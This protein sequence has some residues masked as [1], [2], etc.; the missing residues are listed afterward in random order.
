MKKLLAIVSSFVFL[1]VFTSS[2]M[3]EWGMYGQARL[4]TWYNMQDKD[5]SKTGK[6]EIYFNETLQTNARVGADVTTGDVKGKFEYGADVLNYADT[7]TSKNATKAVGNIR[8]LYGSWNF[9]GGTL[10]V[11]QNYTPV[12]S[13]MV[14]NASKDDDALLQWI[15]EP[16]EGRL[17]QIQFIFGD[18]TIAAIQPKYV[19]ISG[20]TEDD[21]HTYLPKLEIGY[22]LTMD[23]VKATLFGGVNVVKYSNVTTDDHTVYS[24]I[25][26]GRMMANMGDVYVNGDLF[27]A[28]NA[29]NYGL[30][31]AGAAK[32]AEMN[33]K[34]DVENSISYG[35]VFAVG[36]KM[37]ETMTAEFGA[38]YVQSD[39]R[40]AKDPDAAVGVYAQLRYSP[41]S[42]VLITPEIGYV[43]YLDNNQGADEGSSIYAGAKWQINF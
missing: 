43:D 26:G 40:S 25:V 19:S 17:P 3:A 37:D 39:V 32:T 28:Q 24:G 22:N 8:L 15:G 35:G 7:T 6:E 38:G 12:D 14:S 41:I 20:Y 10:L 16:Y 1:C 18:L 27:F 29:N 31:M 36:G 33:S 23:S 4:G 42:A 13:H 2:A 30:S 11:G 5:L 34:N 21:Y 9:G